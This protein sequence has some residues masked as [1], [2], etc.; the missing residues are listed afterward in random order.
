MA[1]TKDNIVQV[2][3]S[4]TFAEQLTKEHCI[5][6]INDQHDLGEQTVTLPR[7][8]VLVFHGSGALLNGTIVG[9]DSVIRAEEK[10]FY[11]VQVKGTWKCIGNAGWFAESSDIV[12]RNNVCY[13]QKY[14]NE[15]TGL[16]AALDSAFRELVIPPKAYYIGSTLVLRKEKKIVM[17]GSGM[18]LGLE[19]CQPNIANTAILFSDLNIC[20][21]RIAVNEGMSFNQSMVQ[22]EGGNF[23]VSLCQ[24]YTSNC[25]E[26]RSD[27]NE[28][29]W[30]LVINT[31]VKG[32]FGNT[33]GVGINI[34]AIENRYSTG[35]ITQVRINSNVSNFGT[36][37]K[38][39]N[40]MDIPT[41]RYYNWCTDVT[42]DGAIINC[43]VAIDCDTDDCDIRAMVQAGYF[44]DSK[45]NDS[46]LIRLNTA[47]GAISSNVFDIR[48]NGSGK[49][50]NNYALNI[51][52]ESCGIVPYGAFLAQ[53]AIYQGTDIVTGHRERLRT[54][55]LETKK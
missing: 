46:A 48:L 24:S 34:N 17:Q 53:L 47:R 36:G 19:Q 12:E 21:L 15:S 3:T 41:A 52:R 42:I 29:L 26:V 30:G 35:Y 39:A 7:G 14:R 27:S 44:F 16:Q 25:I 22:I 4:K 11:D 13:I 32:K 9:Q 55:V 8:S 31:N 54:T 10:V 1:K 49:W 51:V 37:V 33:Y 40:Y 23:D 43:P 38:A 45:D 28:K 6:K 18:K 2:N 20:L 50:S 5:Y